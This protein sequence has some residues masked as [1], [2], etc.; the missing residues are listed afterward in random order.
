[1]R[2]LGIAGSPRR[3][4]NTDL[5]LVEVMR[6]AASQGA[7]VKTIILDEL[8][9]APCQHCD[10]CLKKGK[11]KIQDDMQMIYRELEQADRI[12]LASPVHFMGVS[13]QM[14]AMIDRCQALWARK[15]VLK[16]PPLRDRRERKGLFISVAGR[17]V[18]NVFDGSV[19]TIKSLFTVMDVIYAG[20]LLFR[21]IDEKGDITKHPEA[22]RQA[23]LAGQKL[24]T[25]VPAE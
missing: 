6:G 22:L 25:D 23:F 14:K 15:Y 8:D 4:G 9:I 20:D 2:V 16:Q 1:M 13:A 12:V 24:V 10:T 5:L 7:E 18:A 17:K 3:G 21:N 11:C 19:A